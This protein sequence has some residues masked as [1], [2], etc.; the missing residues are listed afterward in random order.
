MKRRGQ[1][2]FGKIRSKPQGLIHSCITQRASIWRVIDPIPIEII[3][4]LRDQA[5]CEREFTILFG[6]FF[7]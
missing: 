5:I 7:Q 1:V 2:N 4:S 6:R 3:V